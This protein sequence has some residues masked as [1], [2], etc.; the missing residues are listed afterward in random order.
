MIYVMRVAGGPS[1]ETY[2]AQDIIGLT[3]CVV[4]W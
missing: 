2:R 3:M 1:L 4:G